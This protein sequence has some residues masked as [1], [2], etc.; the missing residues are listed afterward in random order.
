MRIIGLLL[1]LF[2]L[3]CTTYEWTK[4]GAEQAD[5]EADDSQCQKENRYYEEPDLSS[6]LGGYSATYK[7]QF[8]LDRAS[9]HACMEARGWTREEQSMRPTSNAPRP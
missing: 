2:L 5:F 9:Y 7:T 6:G 3:G 8:K 4:P 1:T